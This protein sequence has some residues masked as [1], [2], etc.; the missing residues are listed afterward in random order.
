MYKWKKYIAIHYKPIDEYEYLPGIGIKILNALRAEVMDL[1]I[2]LHVRQHQQQYRNQYK[3]QNGHIQ[4]IICNEACCK[5][6]NSGRCIYDNALETVNHFVMECKQFQ[7]QRNELQSKIAPIFYYYNIPFTLKT[8]FFAPKYYI[9]DNG[10]KKKLRWEH[11]K[12]VLNSIIAYKKKKKR[13]NW[14]K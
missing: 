14:F 13:I 1:N 9:N 10:E 4:F 5:E 12:M 8:L 3:T 11:R 6:N 7:I 2:N